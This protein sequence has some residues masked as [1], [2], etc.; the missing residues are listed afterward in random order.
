MEKKGSKVNRSLNRVQLLGNVV[1]D[2]QPRK[3]SNDISFC[4]V[5]IATDRNW[6][7]P[8]GEEREETQFH[9]V[10]A[11]NKLADIF[12]ELL[13]KG[14]KVYVEGRLQTRR[15]TTSGGEEKTS[16]EIVAEK[17]ILLN[18]WYGKEK[19]EEGGNPN[20]PLPK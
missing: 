2:A 3:T 4:S 18:G 17:M 16:T 8:T 20:E 1:A 10:I 5:I 11:W 6:T 7:L 12:G 19:T 9:R 15:Y 14:K 13:L